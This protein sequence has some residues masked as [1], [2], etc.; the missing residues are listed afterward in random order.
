MQLKI[1]SWNIWYDGYFDIVSKFLAEA[2]AD[3][4]GIQEIVPNDPKRNVIGFLEKLGY[5]YIVAPVLTTKD[6]RIMSNAIFSK[7]PIESSERYIL[8]EEKS[9][10]ALRA[11][12][13]IGDKTLH[14]F[15]THLL[16]THQ[17][18]SETQELQIDNL[19]K[20]LPKEKT[21]LMGDFNATPESDTIKKISDILV[22][23]DPAQ[24]PT[25][26]VYKEGCSVCNLEEVNIRL[27]YIFTTSDIKTNTPEVYSLKG[28]DHL[29]ISV[30]VEI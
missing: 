12:I 7:Y 11:Y 20:V 24:T 23:T 22:N 16:H 2:D 25:L 15:C 1:L 26:C 17:Q 10:N 13:K 9:R 29:P 5:K 27:D 4:I 18:P 6:G 8:S 3:I 19:I 30:V 28:S 14:V 21:I